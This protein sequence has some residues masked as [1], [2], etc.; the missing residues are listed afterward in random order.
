V[1]VSGESL[2]EEFTEK[3][4]EA[5][6]W[7][8]ALSRVSESALRNLGH[9]SSLRAK[10]RACALLLGH[11]SGTGI[12]P[13]WALR[14]LLMNL[15]I[16]NEANF[17]LNMT[18]D[19]TQRRDAVG[20]TAGR[21]EDGLW[22]VHTYRSGRRGLGGE[23]RLTASGTKLAAEYTA[24]VTDAAESEATSRLD[25][26]KRVKESVART[27]LIR[28]KAPRCAFCREDITAEDCARCGCG[29]E[30]HASCLDEFNSSECW[31]CPGIGCTRC[32]GTKRI[33]KLSCVLARTTARC[34]GT[35]TI[36]AK[37]EAAPVAD[38]PTAE[39]H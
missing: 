3:E 26:R 30:V 12:V 18:K 34:R 9:Q 14:E 27:F 25:S 33:V 39:E 11:A 4:R 29:G 32:S 19:S 28:P 35:Y 31:S 38:E 36:I 15:G 20:T 1:E 6:K 24:L 17:T 13:L 8:N 2:R 21:G 7:S 37:P 5:I 23:W 10:Q 16:Y 22:T